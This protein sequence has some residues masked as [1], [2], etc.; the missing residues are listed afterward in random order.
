MCCNQWFKLHYPVFAVHLATFLTF[1]PISCIIYTEPITSRMYLRWDEAL[2]I[3]GVTDITGTVNYREELFKNTLSKWCFCIWTLEIILSLVVVRYHL[4]R[5]HHPKFYVTKAN[6]LSIIFHMV[7][8][9]VAILGFYVGAIS[10]SKLPCFLAAISG[11]FLHLLSTLWQ[12]RQLHGQREI[13]IP[14][15][16][17]C[18][19]LL[20]QSYIDLFLYD[21]NFNTVFTAGILLNSYGL[22]RFWYALSLKM[23]VECSYDRT[24]M[25]A[26]FTNLVF[27]LGIFSAVAVLSAIYV[28]NLWF[29]ILKPMPRYVLQIERGYNDTIPDVLEKKR[30][31]SFHE[32]LNRQLESASNKEEAIAKA[33]W[34]IIASTDSGM[35]LEDVQILF[36]SWGMPDAIPAA[37]EYFQAADTDNNST[38]DYKEFKLAFRHLIDNIY[39]KGEYEE[40]HVKRKQKS[41]I[42]FA[43]SES[44]CHERLSKDL[45]HDL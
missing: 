23:G 9:T 17:V 28:W 10:N 1:L 27:I 12:T 5:P 45:S 25:F 36:Q 31:I 41:E 22:V 32:E 39:V 14:I 15:Y 24:I 6:R 19:Y 38:I 20:L 11:I 35:D 40:L 30:G 2:P 33:L 43:A 29:N 44:F 4:Y 21:F 8:G 34:K 3:T 42:A 37:K 7:G 13:S 16:F 26:A 18:A